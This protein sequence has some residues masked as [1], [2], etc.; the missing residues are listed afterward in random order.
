MVASSNKTLC[1]THY[2]LL[3]IL[4]QIGTCHSIFCCLFTRRDTTHL[5]IWEV[6]F[7]DYSFSH[8]WHYTPTFLKVIVEYNT[9]NTRPFQFLSCSSV[10]IGSLWWLTLCLKVHCLPVPSPVS[11]LPG[12]G[13]DLLCLFCAYERSTW[14]NNSRTDKKSSQVFSSS[15]PLCLKLHRI[16]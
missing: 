12:S 11:P 8:S 9:N 3:R 15:H 4:Q 10:W 5:L 16:N 1:S 13:R 14:P 2:F 6:Y 7:K